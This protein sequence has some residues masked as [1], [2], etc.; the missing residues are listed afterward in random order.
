MFGYTFK[1]S[2]RQDP[3]NPT[4]TEVFCASKTP[5][6]G[7]PFIFPPNLQKMADVNEIFFSLMSITA[8]VFIFY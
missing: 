1:D 4:M 2:S 8:L 7:F 5:D 3:T 6:H